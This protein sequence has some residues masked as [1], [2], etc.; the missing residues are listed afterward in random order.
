MLEK[1]KAEKRWFCWK[2]ETRP[3]QDKPTK[4]PYSAKTGRKTGTDAKFSDTW[5]DFDSASKVC[6]ERGYS[7]VGFKIPEDMFFLDIDHT[8]P[9][10]P[11]V[12][13]M[14]DL[15]NT[16]AEYSQSGAGVHFYGY[17]NSSKIPVEWNEKEGFL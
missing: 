3:G 15:L 13:R 10:D 16:Y 6:A 1:L 8:T 4:V 7:G 11:R 9:D 2:L 5:T 12:S 17:V 14:K